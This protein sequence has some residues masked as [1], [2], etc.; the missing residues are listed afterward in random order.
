MTYLSGFIS[1]PK[2]F[3]ATSDYV[4]ENLIDSTDN[5]ERAR[6]YLFSGVMDYVVNTGVVK[7]T[8]EFFQNYIRST[9]IKSIYTLLS[10][11]GFVCI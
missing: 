8:Q 6:V 7:K 4:A 2:I 9:N 10:A 11:H 3:Q 5:L 1:L